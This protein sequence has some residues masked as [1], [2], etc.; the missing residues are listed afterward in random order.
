VALGGAAP[1]AAQTPPRC[2]SFPASHA[3]VPDARFVRVA[4]AAGGATRRQDPL[5][6][7]EHERNPELTVSGV[8][9]LT[10]VRCPMRG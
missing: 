7:F 9:F 5:V 8:T 1:P 6:G 4:V 2:T 3:G 10:M